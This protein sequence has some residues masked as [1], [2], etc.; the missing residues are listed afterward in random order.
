MPASD[1]LQHVEEPEA[2]AARW[3]GQAWRGQGQRHVH[4]AIAA[5]DV[6]KSFPGSLSRGRCAFGGS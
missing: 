2:A 3:R 6:R 1:E 4:V 5:A